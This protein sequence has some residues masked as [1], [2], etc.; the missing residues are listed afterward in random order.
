M[1]CRQRKFSSSA[2]CRRFLKELNLPK[3]FDVEK[4][5]YDDGTIPGKPQ[6]DIYLKAANKLGLEPKDCIVVEDA[7]SGINAAYAA[8]IGKIIAI[9]SL[10]S[11][12]IYK[13][14]PYVNQIIKDFSNFD[15]ILK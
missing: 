8:G 10:E 3:W 1:Y 5:V 14:L 11:P 15:E 13:E 12:D 2:L 7:I 4:I 9:A 6:P